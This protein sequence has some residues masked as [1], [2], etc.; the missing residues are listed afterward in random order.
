MSEFFASDFEGDPMLKVGAVLSS[1]K[2]DE[3]L[4]AA[5][6]LPAASEAVAEAKVI[7]IVPS[8]VQ[9][10]SVTVRV[11]LPAPLTAAV[12]SAVPVLLTLTSASASVTDEA[13]V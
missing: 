7:P 12:Q 8:P 3:A 5:A 13:P 1:A 11:E 6:V 2:V 4:G 10:E 9:L